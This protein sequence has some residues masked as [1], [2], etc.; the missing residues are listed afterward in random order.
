MTQDHFADRLNSC[1]EGSGKC[2]G[3]G[4][5]A[6]PMKG[7]TRKAEEEGAEGGKRRSSAVHDAGGG[8][9]GH[10][11]TGTTRRWGGRWG[12]GMVGRV[13]VPHHS[14]EEVQE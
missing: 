13:R 2:L 3:G 12:G 10:G 6:N 9:G 7:A 4:D 8:K 1:M 5:C 11:N 14:D